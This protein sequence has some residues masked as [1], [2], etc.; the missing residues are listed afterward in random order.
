MLGLLTLAS[1]G[2]VLKVFMVEVLSLQCVP[3]ET[4]TIYEGLQALG[5]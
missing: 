4:I 5:A 3:K 2:H 1:N